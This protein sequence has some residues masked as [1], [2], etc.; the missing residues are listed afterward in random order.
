MSSTST[1]DRLREYVKRLA[2]ELQETQDELRRADERDSEPIAVVGMACRYPGGVRSPEDLWTVLRDGVDA[3]GP[4]PADRGWDVEELYDP[5][6]DAAGHSYVREGGFLHDAAQFDPAF[7]EMSPREAAAAD[8]QQRLL[9][10]TAWESLERARIRPG[11]LHGSATG[12]FVGVMYDDYGSRLRPAPPGFE[13]YLVSGSAGSVASG[14]V[15]YA[16]GLQ[17]PAVTVDTACSSSLVSL[18][19]ACRSLRAGECSLALAG[20]VTVMATPATFVEFSRQRGLAPD[21]RCKP[22]AAAADGTG[23]A[24]GVGLVVLELLSDAR[25]NGHRVLALIR[26]SAVNQDGASNGLTAPNGPSQERVIRAALAQARLTPH[27]VDAVEAH[28]TGTELGD[29]IEAQALLAAYGKNRLPDRP[30]R[31]GSVKSNLGHTQAAAGVAGVIKLVLALRHGELPRTLHVDAPSP[32]VDWSSGAI[33]LLT[34]PAPWPRSADRPR[35]AA[36]SSFGISGTN[37]HVIV[38]EAPEPDVPDGT[39]S[40]TSTSPVPW[41]LS[42]RDAGAL[43]EQ[44]ERLAEHVSATSTADIRAIGM[45]LATTRTAF[46][47]RAVV[48]GADREDLVAGLRAVAAGRPGV[49]VA[50]GGVGPRARTAFLFTGQGSQRPGMGRELYET[51]PAYSEAFDELCEV[52]DPGLDQPLRQVVFADPDDPQ[53][54][55]VHRTDFTQA[56]LFALEVAAARLATSWGLE[57]AA[58][59]GH[60]IGGL[61]A[62]H[63]AGVFDLDDAARLVTARGRLMAATRTDGAMAALEGTEADLASLL[64]AEPALSL[65]AVNGPAAVVVSGDQDVVIRAVEQWRAEGRRA[66]KLSV[67][68]AFHSAHMDPALDEFRDVARQLRFRPATIPVV[69]DST[70]RLATDEELSS[71]EYWVRHLRGTVRFHD[72]VRWLH[73]NGVGAF[74]EIGPDA[75]LTVPA[76]ETVANEDGADDQPSGSVF[77]ALLRADRP[78]PQNAVMAAGRLY[79][80]GVDV[81]WESHF[82][83]VFV[84]TVDLPTYPFQRERLWLDAVA[85]TTLRDPADLGQ[86]TAGHPLLGAAVALA[87]GSLAFTGRLALTE[88][89]WLADHAVAGTVLFPGTAFV[90]LALHAGAVTGTPEV[91]ELTLHAPLVLDDERAVQVRLV[92]GAADEDGHR[93]LTFHTRPDNDNDGNSNNNAADWTS[94]ADGTLVPATETLAGPIAS[95]PVDA[96]PADLSGLYESLTERGHEYGPAFQGLKAVWRQG[97]DVYGRVELA[98]P[99]AE[100]FLVHPALLDSALHALLAVESLG[101]QVPFSWT[102][103]RV[104]HAV[105]AVASVHLRRTGEDRLTLDLSDPNGRPVLSIAELVTRPVDPAALMAA[106]AGPADDALFGVEWQAAELHTEPDDGSDWVLLDLTPGG[107]DPDL[108]AETH[109]TAERSLLLLQDWLSREDMQN[110]HLVVLTRDAAAARPGD[111]PDLRQATVTG[112]VR[113]AQNEHPGRITVLD[114]DDHPFSSE[115]VAVAVATA[116]AEDEPYSALRAG[117]R[118]VP[119]LERAQPAPLPL[120]PPEQ[121]AAWRLGVAAPGSVDQL[122]FLPAP[123]LD[124]PLEPG[125][126]RVRPEAVGLNFRDVLIALGMYPEPAPHLGSEGAGTITEVGPE[127]EGF[128]VGDRV[129]GILTGGSGAVTVTDHRVL[130]P[131][132]PAWSATEAAGAIVVY[133]T[134]Y[135]ALVRLTDLRPGE[136]LLIHT[137]TGGVGQAATHLARHLGARVF[138]TASL[139][140]QHTLTG[141]LGYQTEDIADSRSHDY[142]EHF[143]ARSDQDGVDVVL[144]SLANEHTDS[145]LR[146]LPRGGRFI[147]MSKTDI[148]DPATVAADHPGVA[149][150]AIDLADAGPDGTRA[151]LAALAPLFADGTLPPIPATALPIERAPQALRY[152][153]QAQHTGKITLTLPA[154]A[155]PDGTTLITGGT[156][157]L[158]GLTALHLAEHR[159]HRRFLLVSRSGADAPGAEEL[160][161]RLT[162]LG[163]DVD[164]VAADTSDPAS[165]QA[166]LAKVPDQ[167]PITTVVHT[168]G[169]LHDAVFS[170][171][172][173]AQ[174]HGALRPKVDTAHLLHTA[175][176]PHLRQ[177]IFYSSA[178]ATLANPGQAAY[179][180][181]NSFLDALAHHRTDTVSIGWGLWQKASALTQHLTA[182]DLTRLR[183]HGLAPLTTDHAL[184][185]LDASPA[186]A[187]RTLLALPL[188]PDAMRPTPALL[189]SLARAPRRVPAVAEGGAGRAAA[190]DF[191]AELRARPE[192]ER[193]AA[194]LDLVRSNAAI[195]LGHSASERVRSDH[196]FKEQGFDSLT[197][198]ELRNL[199]TAATGLRLPGAM[200]FDYPTP[201][202]LAE[203]IVA[204]LAAETPASTA[205]AAELAA[206]EKAIA[207]LTGPGTEVDGDVHARTTA[208]LEELARAWASAGSPDAEPGAEQDFTAASDEDLFAA[209]DRGFSAD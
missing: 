38:E 75:V 189:R 117:E 177:L 40:Q 76:Q 44:A 116:R 167:H 46:D 6:P 71:P 123:D 31:L 200:V 157:T 54:A 84:R 120:P 208:R 64:A 161:R 101:T 197:A 185:L 9:L 56:G 192:P 163:A 23:W 59:L 19:L 186:T 10:E 39:A 66:R 27:D 88:Q 100:G 137:A 199:L 81:A 22:F 151:I 179:N 112:L 176:L 108:V 164:V 118:F 188:D 158:A 55:L 160:L 57:P 162:E 58:V 16:L 61:A 126:V 122:T 124:A 190:Q 47:Q 69:S 98:A 86:R 206:L 37:A 8:P 180:A 148:R 77:A 80:R 155:D 173:P 170:A 79:A 141:A 2:A 136:R 131:V 60:S 169:A 207:T 202:A 52:L 139:R 127:V 34:E 143:L 72:G 83:R 196:T 168:A 110:V 134:A 113:T 178:A 94:H 95:V 153:S 166:V 107:D 53:A 187:R 132:P 105:G 152:L 128:Q 209:F 194:A 201:A 174:L 41:V 50:V 28:G 1:E 24:E 93:K 99:I 91:E 20:G 65:A 21:G 135:Y 14:R 63:V 109:A 32:R 195:V 205:L 106:A 129:M 171:L 49:N 17:G 140:K 182:A 204:L 5:S 92:L 3:V 133:A 183:T 181:A 87:D 184:H 90:D 4:F 18:H 25:R 29:P 26:G 191:A 104:H 12:V 42:A 145:T 89:P 73:Q 30:L 67:Q 175:D 51:Y 36:V 45:S 62:A 35:R 48:V 96:V 156:G 33:S 82:D 198:V 138:A 172:T 68:H 13:G 159:G 43:R 144:H 147:D 111:V 121:D 102:G 165:F 149:Y 115:A 7:F 193:R 146:L 119:R 114:I 15:S 154:P 150:Q 130:L 74:L 78:E 70:G 203:R 97:E 85:D 11:D 125:Q 103:I 142:V